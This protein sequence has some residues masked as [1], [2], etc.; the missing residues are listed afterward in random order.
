M[1]LLMFP[2]LILA[3]AVASFALR[4]MFH[5]MLSDAERMPLLPAHDEDEYMQDED[6]CSKCGA[7]LIQGEP[8]QEFDQFETYWRQVDTT[9]SQQFTERSAS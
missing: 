9:T 2:V 4:T 6:V 8:L 7:S 5:G 1:I 3:I